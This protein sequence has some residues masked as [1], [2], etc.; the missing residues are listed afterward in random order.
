MSDAYFF[1]PVSGAIN[2]MDAL[3]NPN[4]HRTDGSVIDEPPAARSLAVATASGAPIQRLSEHLLFAIFDFVRDGHAFVQSEASCRAFCGLLQSTE[5][6]GR[7]L[8]EARP[9]RYGYEQPIPMPHDENP[10]LPYMQPPDFFLKDGGRRVVLEFA[11][12]QSLDLREEYCKLR[13]GRYFCPSVV[14]TFVEPAVWTQIVTELY[15]RCRPPESHLPL[16]EFSECFVEATMDIVES[17]F[18][19]LLQNALKCAVHRGSTMLTAADIEL[20]RSIL[21]DTTMPHTLE[22]DVKQARRPHLF[23]SRP[24]F[25]VGALPGISVE[26]K[27]RIIRTFVRRVQGLAFNARAYELM[28]VLLVARLLKLLTRVGE[29]VLYR[30]DPAPDL[31]TTAPQRSTAEI[32]AE[33]AGRLGLPEDS[34]IVLQGT[35]GQESRDTLNELARRAV[36]SRQ[37]VLKPLLADLAFAAKDDPHAPCYSWAEAW[38]E[39][40]AENTTED[41]DETD[42]D[43]SSIGEAA[44]GGDDE[45]MSDSSSSIGEGWVGGELGSDSGSDSES[46]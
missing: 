28:W 30:E 34:N 4:P 36:V 10:R 9:I 14:L 21:D 18:T 2:Q 6:I 41:E 13:G 17:W 5:G 39:I 42:D 25:S 27:D 11:A 8:W 12:L 20:A 22:L 1:S 3:R 23:Q 33:I 44:A 40:G 45:S 35:R 46:S 24:R 43:D 7:K 15:A 38:D 29:L 26:V 31:A 37:L 32:A 16:L 19:K